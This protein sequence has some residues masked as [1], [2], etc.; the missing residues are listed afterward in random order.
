M[1]EGQPGA[2]CCGGTSHR[3]E[4]FIF[5]L[6]L[7]PFPS[8]LDAFADSGGGGGGV[9]WGE[10]GVQQRGLKS[11]NECL[12]KAFPTFPSFSSFLGLALTLQTKGGASDLLIGGVGREGG[13]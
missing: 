7:P 2:R 3:W 1:A 12:I 6:I 11:L 13:S 8:L 10:A 9:G 5:L 4:A